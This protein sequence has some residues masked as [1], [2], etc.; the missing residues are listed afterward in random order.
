[1]I[2]AALGKRAS[3]RTFKLRVFNFRTT[4]PLFDRQHFRRYARIAILEAQ[5][6]V[7]RQHH[8]QKNHAREQQHKKEQLTK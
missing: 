4:R 7:D 1:M 6:N 2:Q 3:A 5:A 8:V